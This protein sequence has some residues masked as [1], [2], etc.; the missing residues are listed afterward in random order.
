MAPLSMVAPLSD[1]S[2]G[3]LNTSVTDGT[4]DHAREDQEHEG[5]DRK[6]DESREALLLASLVSFVDPDDD[7]DDDRQSNHAKDDA[8]DRACRALDHAERGL[9]RRGTQRVSC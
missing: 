7:P 8:E 3:E 4:L 1:R 5:D 9:Y 6:D 2:L